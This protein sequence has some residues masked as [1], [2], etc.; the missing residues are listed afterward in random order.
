MFRGAVLSEAELR[1]LRRIEDV[2]RLGHVKR[3]DRERILL[4][5]GSV[6]TSEGTAHIHCAARGLLRRP[7]VP[8]FE[9]GRV[10]VQ[11]FLWGFACFQFAMPG[12]VEATLEDDAEKNRL[13]SPVAYW[14]PNADYL[15]AFLATLVNERSRA[16]HPQLAR[17][18]KE[19]R[20]NRWERSRF[21][22]TLW[23]SWMLGNASSASRPRRQAIW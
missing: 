22:A 6:P 20:L 15:A 5:Q 19:T 1:L 18:T 14:D 16:A 17:W 21:T 9:G 23:T 10:T 3:I 7:L 13:C 12:V 11:P 2:V 8:I 4:E